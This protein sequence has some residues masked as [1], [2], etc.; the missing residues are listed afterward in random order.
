MP[1]TVTVKLP[2]EDPVHERV[3][4]PEPPVTLVGFRVH[5]RPVEGETVSDNATVPVNP[6]VPVTV[7]VEVPGEPATTLM[8][9]GLADKVKLGAALIV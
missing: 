3:D 8:V 2:V 9:V 5:V 6:L 4:V 1:V 7:T